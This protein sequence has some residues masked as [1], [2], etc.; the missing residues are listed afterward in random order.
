MKVL[1]I[2]A[3]TNY[4][5]EKSPIPLGLLSIATFLESYGY[6][7]HIYDRA[8]DGTSL[9]KVV[10][11]FEPTLVGISLISTKGFADAKRLTAYFSK[12]NIPVV[13]GGP[14]ASLVPKVI[15]SSTDA[16][17]VVTG[18]GEKPMLALIKALEN[19]DAVDQIP[20]LAFKRRGQ[21]CVNERDYNADLSGLPALD[22]TLIDTR[23]YILKNVY[24]QKM[25]HTF[26]SKGCIGSCGYCYNPSF[27]KGIWRPRPIQSV[28]Q[29]LHALKSHYDIHA[30]TFVDDLLRPDR[31]SLLEFCDSIK[32]EGPSLLW[33][34]DLCADS[35]TREDLE[36]MYEAGCRWIFFGI[37]SGSPE[38]QEIIR[39]NLDLEK[40]KTTL[41]ICKEI[42]ICTTTSFIVGFPDETKAHLKQTVAYANSLPSDV[43]VAFS[44]G[45]I[46]T[47]LLYR[48]L[49]QDKRL[50]ECD[51]HTQLGKYRWFD[52]FGRNF[53]AAP[54]RDC[55]VISACFYLS[56]L[57]NRV[58]YCGEEKKHWVKRF[59]AQLGEMLRMKSLRGLKLILISAKEFTRILFY[60]L[61]FPRVRREYGLQLRRKQEKS[62]R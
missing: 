2:N 35:L 40:A 5:M 59:A 13:W 49:I 7:T 53:S 18:D 31:Q 33:G 58:Q 46:P 19:R 20:G 15:L 51:E 30:V 12:R 27:S 17:F 48:R 62:S 50:E 24:Q 26:T 25:L 29:D 9:R 42:G 23:R 4:V 22:W 45:P 10:R 37:E 56:L 32:R 60:G 43:K 44:F 38:M 34:C 54:P 1:L 14:A 61:M 16:R 21:V 55:K 6:K 57:L 28:L 41:E 3:A 39:K 8:T 52:S 47:T 36:R 11:R